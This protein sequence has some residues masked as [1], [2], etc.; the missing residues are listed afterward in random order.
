MAVLGH[1]VPGKQERICHY[2]QG[3]N[4]F[5]R[6]QLGLHLLH[7]NTSYSKMSRCL[8]LA[9]YGFWFSKSLWTGHISE[10]YNDLNT[11]SL[12]F[13]TSRDLDELTMLERY[14]MIR[15]SLSPSKLYIYIYIY[16]YICVCVC[17]CVCVR[18]YPSCM[19]CSKDHKLTPNPSEWLKTHIY[20]ITT[21]LQL[22]LYWA[23]F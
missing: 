19:S 11:Q 15:Y 13:G 7:S 12:I 2:R 21:N 1:L 23:K 4:T 14:N 20:E 9:R 17:V 6:K 10:Q 8:D 18:V 16:I 22:L 5:R 3:L